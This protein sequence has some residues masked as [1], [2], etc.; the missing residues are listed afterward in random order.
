LVQESAPAGGVNTGK[1]PGCSGRSVFYACCTWRKALVRAEG[2]EPSRGYP[3]RIFVPSTTFAASPN[4][5]ALQRVCGLDYTFTLARAR[6][7]CCPSSLYTFAS[8]AQP[9]TLGSGLPVTGSPEFEQFC[10]PSFPRGTQFCLSPLR[11]P[12][13]HAR[14]NRN[15][16]IN[17]SLA[18]RKLKLDFGGVLAVFSRHLCGLCRDILSWQAWRLEGHT[19]MTQASTMFLM[20]EGG[21]VCDVP[22]PA[23][24]MCDIGAICSSRSRSAGLR[25]MIPERS[26][27]WRGHKSSECGLRQPVTGASAAAAASAVSGLPRHPR[28]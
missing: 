5:F 18:K 21:I 7:R 20:W 26:S 12:F 8:V 15:L 1:R 6:L 14:T 24:L 23:S 17:G 3:Q 4:A 19:L 28:A 9:N 13:R 2:I 25:D 11:L 22:F 27:G 10:S 16:A